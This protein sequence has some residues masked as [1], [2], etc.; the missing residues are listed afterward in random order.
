V[1]EP[2][3]IATAL[4]GLARLAAAKNEAAEVKR[5]LGEAALVRKRSSRPAP[6]HELRDLQGLTSGAGTR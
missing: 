1:G 5:L 2:G 4:E 3:L 6:P